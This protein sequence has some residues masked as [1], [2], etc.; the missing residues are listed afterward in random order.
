MYG[1]KKGY[2]IRSMANAKRKRKSFFA[3]RLL[4]RNGK[5]AIEIGVGDLCPVEFF[6]K[7]RKHAW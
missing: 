2:T 7:F 4:R 6:Y 3:I 5:V 1:K